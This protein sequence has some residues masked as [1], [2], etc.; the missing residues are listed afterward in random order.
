MNPNSQNPFPGSAVHAANSNGEETLRLIAN[1]P[2]P[3]GLED[4]VHE[5]LRSAPRRGRVLPW[6]ARLSPGGGWM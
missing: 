4:R 1:L 2:A 5:V 6:P 3:E